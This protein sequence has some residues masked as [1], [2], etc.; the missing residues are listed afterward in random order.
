MNFILFQPYYVNITTDF[1]NSF[2]YQFLVFYLEIKIILKFQEKFKKMKKSRKKYMIFNEIQGVLYANNQKYVE[3][4]A[5]RVIL[6]APAKMTSITISCGGRYFLPQYIMF[7]HW[8]FFG[9][10]IKVPITCPKNNKNRVRF[11]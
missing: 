8:T 3:I 6:I 1:L 2:F 4:L 5:L 7:P 10:P 11:L 9:V